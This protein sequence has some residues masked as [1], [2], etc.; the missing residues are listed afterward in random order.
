MNDLI[1]KDKDDRNEVIDKVMS[2]FGNFEISKESIA[3]AYDSVK[4]N[5][6]GTGYFGNNVAEAMVRGFEESVEKSFEK[7]LVSNLG[8]FA[9]DI[10]D[11]LVNKPKEI[12]SEIQEKIAPMSI[13]EAYK[14]KLN[15][16]IDDIIGYRYVLN[17]LKLGRS[18]LRP[19]EAEMNKRIVL[20]LIA[21]DD[22][23]KG[24]E[25]E[26]LISAIT[27][28]D[29][30]KLLEAMGQGDAVSSDPEVEELHQ[31]AKYIESLYPPEDE[32][33]EFDRL[34]AKD[35]SINKITFETAANMNSLRE[36]IEKRAKED[37]RG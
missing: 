19:A 21:K 28:Y 17:M 30:V 11:D 8:T 12:V 5:P 33:E 9:K 37:S 31:Y 15:K 36:E 6:A 35:W 27:K 16:I 18:L 2:E 25:K 4:F 32:Q 29:F 14:G 20:A 10:I 24:A 13:E 3:A 26:K 22:T 1:E 23:Y 34:S 7:Y